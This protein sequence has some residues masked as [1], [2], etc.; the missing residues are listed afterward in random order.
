M[1]KIDRKVLTLYGNENQ[2]EIIN[3]QN[4][5]KQP[6]KMLVTIPKTKYFRIA[7]EQ[8]SFVLAAGMNKKISIELVQVPNDHS[9][10][11]FV[12]IQT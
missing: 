6:M 2:E 4:I 5:G 7:E 9:C 11:D 12:Q 3:V 8:R 1:F 10:L